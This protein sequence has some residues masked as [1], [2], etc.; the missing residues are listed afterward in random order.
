MRSI[1]LIAVTMLVASSLAAQSYQLVWSDEFNGNSLDT[2]K[3]G[4]QN[5]C[6]GAG[7]NELECYTSRTQNVAVRNGTLV[8]TPLVENYGGR[9][10]TSGRVS[11]SGKYSWK[12]GRFDVRAKIPDGIYLWP[13]IWM[14][15]ERSV[16]GSWAL[17]GEIDIMENHGGQNREHSSTLHHGGQWPKNTNTGSGSRQASVDLTQDFHVY[18]AIWTPESIQFALDGDVYFTVSLQRS[19]NNAAAG[20]FP[21][22]NNGAPFDQNFHFIINLAIGGGFF[23]GNS[24]ALTQDQA[25]AWRSPEFLIDY[26]RVYQLKDGVVAPPTPSPNPAPAPSTPSSTTC[27][28]MFDSLE[29][30]TSSNDINRID[31]GKISG[32]RN[33]LCTAQPKYCQDIGQGAI[34]SSCNAAEQISYAMNGYYRDFKSSQGN[35]A[36]DFGGLGG[37]HA[38]KTSSTTKAA[39]T[40]KASSTTKAAASTTV[41]CPSGESACHDALWGSVCYRTDGP[42]SCVRGDDNLSHLCPKGRSACGAACYPADQ[43][44]C[45]GGWLSR[46]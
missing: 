21:Y 41:N 39:S 17:S 46:K 40:T 11:T 14:M 44:R 13:A 31:A 4:Y 24:Q 38:P 1:A 37:V 29:C 6:D 33:W 36:C 34:Y 32:A 30:R 43:Y 27:Q 28:K 45:S 22:A 19:F 20:S 42:F 23:G 26:A 15:P 25:R 7:N 10:Y 5:L 18:S 3:W 35:G 8:I 12:Y 9:K 2:S 16:Y